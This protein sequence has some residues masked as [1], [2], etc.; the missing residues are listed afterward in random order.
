VAV[1]TRGTG[2]ERLV[3]TAVARPATGVGLAAGV[4][5]GALMIGALPPQLARRKAQ[6]TNKTKIE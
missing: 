4:G 5:L 3:G 2:L 1:N 6:A